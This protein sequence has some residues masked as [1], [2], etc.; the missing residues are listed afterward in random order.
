[1]IPFSS[2]SFFSSS[3]KSDKSTYPLP[4]LSPLKLYL[5]GNILAFSFGF[6]ARVTITSER[7][8]PKYAG[9]LLPI[10]V[11]KISPYV[12]IKIFYIFN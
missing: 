1:M 12:Y 9:S 6:A 7:C 2:K 10:E 3:F 8:F 5:S 4:F 11:I